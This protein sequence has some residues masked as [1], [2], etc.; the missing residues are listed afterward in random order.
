MN[1]KKGKISHWNDAKDRSSCNVFNSLHS[2]CT[3]M[4]A[5]SSS[6]VSVRHSVQ[7]FRG[8]ECFRGEE[9]NDGRLSY[10]SPPTSSLSVFSLTTR[11]L[12]HLPSPYPSHRRWAVVLEGEEEARAVK[13]ENLLLRKHNE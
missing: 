11:P 6:M 12:R 10:S 9:V 7:G 3:L 1:D 8:S 4:H 13:P 2:L 5:A